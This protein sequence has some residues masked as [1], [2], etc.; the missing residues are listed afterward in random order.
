PDAITAGYPPALRNTPEMG[1]IQRLTGGQPLRLETSNLN[2]IAHVLQS[3]QV[4]AVV[5][6]ILV[7]QLD[8][9]APIEITPLQDEREVWL[10]SQPHLR[11]DSL[12]RQLAD[13]CAGLFE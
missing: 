9:A 2:L 8:P 7:R 10:L 13:W 12:A 4:S 6:D 5:P 3:G 11:D 1:H